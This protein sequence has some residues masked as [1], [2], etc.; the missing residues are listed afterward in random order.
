MPVYT[1]DPL[2]DPRWAEFVERHP[3]SSIFHTSGWMEALRKTYGYQPVAY[4]TS[5]P[6]Q[7]LRNGIAFCR[8]D[9]WLTG[10]R[11]V[12]LPFSDHCTPLVENAAEMDDLLATVRRDSQKE[13]CRYVEIRPEPTDFHG[14]SEFREAQS[15][16]F[17][18]LD[19]RPSAE[20]LFAS[21]HKTCVQR[22]IRRAEREGLVYK[23]GTSDALLK[24]FYD[25]LLQTR[26]RQG[27]PPQP[28]SWFRN[29]L[30]GLGDKV[31]VRVAYKGGLAISAILTLLHGKTV[32]YKYGGSAKAFQNLGG[33][34]FLLWK[35]IQEA[36]NKHLLL[37]DL[38]RSDDN[39][40]G[41]IQ[42]KSRWGASQSSL[43]YFRYFLGQPTKATSLQRWN[44]AKHLF[45]H[46][47][48][49][50]LAAAGRLLYRHIG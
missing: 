28:L 1:I 49:P 10:K 34:Q 22:K 44:I 47:P 41:L 37:F 6:Q 30:S 8:I 25:L 13:G 48:N 35:T 14:G 7:E 46:I 17:H 15:F 40:S 36:K 32:S 2:H 18:I 21:F 45:S 4:T 9:T 27:L 5:P 23:D 24:S 43:V 42:F 26:R 20:E 19:L 11:L 16:E 50:C 33:N 38:G 12:S 39:D 3:R 29:L 31:R